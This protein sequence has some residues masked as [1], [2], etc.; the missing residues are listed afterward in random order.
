MKNLLNHVSEII[1]SIRN[2]ELNKKNNTPKLRGPLKRYSK[3]DF[4]A[5]ASKYESKS[6]FKAN[7]KNA[8]EAAQNR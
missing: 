3:Q 4:I 6:D 1:S 8:Y 7:D 2:P 5:I